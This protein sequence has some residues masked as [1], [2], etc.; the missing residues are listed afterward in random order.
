MYIP[1][2]G[3]NALPLC[4]HIWAPFVFSARVMFSE[5]VGPREGTRRVRRVVQQC[6]GSLQGGEMPEYKTVVSGPMSDSGS[7]EGD[8][9]HTAAG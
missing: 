5:A 7:C 6:C 3:R 4:N 1:V 8:P 9:L 2:S